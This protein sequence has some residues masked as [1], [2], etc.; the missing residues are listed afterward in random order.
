MPKMQR[1]PLDERYGFFRRNRVD[2]MRIRRLENLSHCTVIFLVSGN[3]LQIGDFAEKSFLSAS[4]DNG[5]VILL[6]GEI[7]RNMVPEP[8]ASAEQ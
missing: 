7:E 5:Q 1:I 2:H 4:R 3:R 6:R 8:P